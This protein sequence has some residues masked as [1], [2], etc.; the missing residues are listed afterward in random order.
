MAS[1]AGRI[2]ED[3]QGIAIAVHADFADAL[4]VTGGAAFVPQ[5]LAAAAPE[6]GF[7]AFL[8]E[9][10]GVGVHPG[11]HENVAGGMVLDNGR[12]QPPIIKS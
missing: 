2:D 5:F 3:E 11:H 10:Q 6:V 1:W 8:G 12:Y 7:A 9:A 4:D